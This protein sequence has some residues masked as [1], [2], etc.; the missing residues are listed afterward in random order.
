M[1]QHLIRFIL[2]FLLFF[3]IHENS[4]NF[5]NLPKRYG[6]P[7]RLSGP[8]FK[9]TFFFIQNTF[10]NLIWLAETLGIG[11]VFKQMRN[12]ERGQPIHPPS[13]GF[14]SLESE[15][16]TP[17]Q[18]CTISTLKSFST[19]CLLPEQQPGNTQRFFFFYTIIRI[20][21]I[22]TL[23]YGRKTEILRLR[24]N[25]AWHSRDKLRS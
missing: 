13:H 8:Y 5:V 3:Y 10:T 16:R 6:G 21:N 2:L 19:T 23:E 15:S 7:S 25:R 4:F 17:F 9:K 1:L 12:R 18:I 11:H 14:L 24:E 22:L 20:A